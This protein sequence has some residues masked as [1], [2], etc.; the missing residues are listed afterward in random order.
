MLCLGGRLENST[1]DSDTTK[2]IILD[3]PHHITQLLVQHYHEQYQHFGEE[4]VIKKTKRM[5]QYCKIKKRD[6][7]PNVQWNALF[8]RL[9]KPGWI[10]LDR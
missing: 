8:Y 6:N 2:P 1:L 9:Y 4:I 3:T 5:C 10:I 7:Y